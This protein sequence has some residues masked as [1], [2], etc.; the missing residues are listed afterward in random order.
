MKPDVGPRLAAISAWL[1]RPV[2]RGGTIVLIAVILAAPAWLFAD[3][4]PSYR[5][6]SDDFVYIAAS[7]GAAGAGGCWTVG[8]AAGRVGAVYLWADGRK[9]CRRAAVVPLLA[10]VLMAGGGLAVGWSRM[11]A[12]ISFHGRTSKQA[13]DFSNGAKH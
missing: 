11:D 8:R 10:T 2:G 12:R 5:L 9:G 6:H 13:L 7:R 3:S 1:A 4:L